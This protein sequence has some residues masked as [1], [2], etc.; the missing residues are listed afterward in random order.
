MV[1]VTDKPILEFAVEARVDVGPDEDVG[2]GEGDVVHF[3]P[4]LGGTVEGPRLRGAVTPS[5]GNW[6]VRRGPT[7]IQLDA[8]C[9]L[10]ADD[11]ALIDVVNWGFM[12][13]PFRPVPRVASWA[14][15][16]KGGRDETSEDADRVHAALPQRG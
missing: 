3:V 11:G 7:T 14:I 16:G 9:L 12:P 10:R 8:R 6:Y 5:G 1:A 15:T 2:N 13:I 4:I